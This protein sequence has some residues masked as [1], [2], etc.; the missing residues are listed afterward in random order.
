MDTPTDAEIPIQVDDKV[1]LGEDDILPK[2]KEIPVTSIISIQCYEDDRDAH[3]L[4][5]LQPLFV[6]MYDPD[7][8]F[9]R[10]LEVMV[11]SI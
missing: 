5:E 7:P 9:I 6:I 1:E 10:R 8:T 11:N 2:F 3:V 4:E